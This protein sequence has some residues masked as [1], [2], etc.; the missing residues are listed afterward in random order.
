MSYR[1]IHLHVICLIRADDVAV[2][3]RGERELK[4]VIIRLVEATYRMVLRLNSKKCKAMR[5]GTASRVGT[6]EIGYASGENRI[7]RGGGVCVFRN[8]SIM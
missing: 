1:I 6:A 5:L 7:G 2:I 3:A 8:K 4:E